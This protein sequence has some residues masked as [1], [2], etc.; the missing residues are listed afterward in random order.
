MFSGCRR[1]ARRA[2]GRST[3]I[4]PPSPPPMQIVAM[5][6]RPPVRFSTFSTCSTMRAPDAPTGWPSAI[7]PPSTLSFASSSAPSARGEPELLR[8]VVGVLPRALAGDHLRGEGL[9]DLPRVEVV[10]AEAVA[11]QDRRRRVDGAEPHL[12]RIEPRPFGVDDAARP[13]VSCS[14]VDGALRGDHQPG[15][16]V[17]DL[18]AVAGRDVAVLAVEER[19]Q[20][21]EIVDGR[22]LAHAVVRRVELALACRTAARPRR[23]SA[24]SSAPPARAGGCAPRT[25]P[26][27]A[28]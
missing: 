27:P 10:E 16:A 3:S 2:H 7:A 15:G 5:P 4:A 23:R 6:R 1:V 28:A 24:P 9:V 21:R 19:P 13:G 25:R 26:S 11:P 8:A 22:V 18:R 14:C 17:G 20:L 12:R